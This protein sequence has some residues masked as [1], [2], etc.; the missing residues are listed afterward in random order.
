VSIPV[1]LPERHTEVRLTRAEFEAMIRP[2]LDETLV[3]LRRA[4]GSAGVA[5]PDV[6]RVLLVGGSSRIPLVGQM[7]TAALDRPIAVDARP[8]DAIALGAA[9][10]AVAAAPGRPRSAP[11]IAAAR[12]AAAVRRSPA[13]PRPG[14]RPAGA[15]GGPGG[16]HPR[17]RRGRSAGPAQ[18]RRRTAVFVRDNDHVDHPGP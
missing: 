2:A 4:I 15:A 5:V 12:R 1:M 8:K 13:R 14:P 3:A 10:T 16:D 7:V 17:G 18:R 6:H 11:V 9:L